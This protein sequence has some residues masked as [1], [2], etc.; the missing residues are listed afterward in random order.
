MR[1]VS[2][3][4]VGGSSVST[5][6]SKCRPVRPGNSSMLSGSSISLFRRRTRFVS[7]VKRR[8]WMGNF[9]KPLSTRRKSFKPVS[10]HRGS[11]V[12][13]EIFWRREKHVAWQHK[14]YCAAHSL[15][16]THSSSLQWTAQDTT[17]ARIGMAYN[18][19]RAH[20][21]DTHYSH[22]NHRKNC[23]EHPQKK[24]QSLGN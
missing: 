24:R 20:T 22:H 8:N 3:A 18:G 13:R 1:F 2:V 21:T 9:L 23:V 7:A 14:K 4:K 12:C 16:A 17:E 6:P 15:R 11:N 19:I 5:L 10:F